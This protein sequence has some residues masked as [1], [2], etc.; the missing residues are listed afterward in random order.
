MGVPLVNQVRSS[1][2]LF[3]SIKALVVGLDYHK[4]YKLQLIS[5]NGN[6][7]KYRIRSCYSD[8]Y[9]LLPVCSPHYHWNLSLFKMS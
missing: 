1:K 4:L 8:H 6:T 5:G 9:L 3:Y 2:T 7:V